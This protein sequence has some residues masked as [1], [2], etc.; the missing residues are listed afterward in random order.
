MP[1]K[2][3][4]VG[5][6]PVIIGEHNVG[7]QHLRRLVH[8]VF[9]IGHS[10][11]AMQAINLAQQTGEPLA[12]VAAVSGG[13]R[14]GKPGTWTRTAFLVIAGDQEHGGAD[15]VDGQRVHESLE[16]PVVVLLPAHLEELADR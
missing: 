16:D 6:D 2:E 3:T 4:A 7:I 10:M 1:A 13:G 5:K 12:A 8:Q 15:G 11:G 9:V 14:V